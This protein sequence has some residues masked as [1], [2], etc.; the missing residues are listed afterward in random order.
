[1]FIRNT[2][3]F[4]LGA[5]A[6]VNASPLFNKR[7]ASSVASAASSAASSAISSVASSA[8]GGSSSSGSSSA[9]G[10]GSSSMMSSSVT[11]SPAQSSA[12]TTV[13]A[14]TGSSAA[15]SA[16]SS[17]ESGL[18]SAA[19]SS[20]TSSAPMPT[21]TSQANATSP[22]AYAFGCPDG[23][24][25]TYVIGMSSYPEVNITQAYDV[26]QNW[27]SAIPP[28][29]MPVNGTGS[30][31]GAERSWMIQNLTVSEKLNNETMNATTGYLNQNWNLTEP[32]MI[33]PSVVIANATS[34]LT[35]YQ[36][37]TNNDTSVQFYVNFCV[38]DQQAGLQAYS[39][40]ATLY[41]TGLNTL[42]TNM[43]MGG[44]NMTGGAGAG[45]ASSSMMSSSMMP[46]SS[47]MSSSM[48]S[49]SMMSSSGA[50]ASATSGASSV[51][52]AGASGASSVAGAATSGAAGALSS[53]LSGA[54]SLLGAV[55]GAAAPSSS[56]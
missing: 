36:N 42:F 53:G 54:S 31:V 14:A 8:T 6:A 24:S 55:T 28:P 29:I 27:T 19:S 41:L 9:S 11:A 33:A 2:A 44:G 23:Y 17:A 56:A 12:A 50:A 37:S 52:S 20:G 21:S 13:T 35:L 22:E 46:S 25:L 39:Q 40:L 45:G 4:A 32:I 1:M 5:T 47:M 34:D 49:S 18:S 26:L 43:T 16:A 7:Q 15:S 48:M 3:L 30:G 51:A 10:S 38:S